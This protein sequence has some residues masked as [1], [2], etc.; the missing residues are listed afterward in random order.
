MTLEPH[1]LDKKT[2]ALCVLIF[3]RGWISI[4]A[5]DS[6]VSFPDFLTRS[7]QGTWRIA[8]TRVSLDS[9]IN[10]FLEGATPEEICQDYSLLSLAQVY[11][12]IAYYLT[13]RDEIDAYLQ[14][15]QEAAEKLQQELKARYGDFLSDL[16]RRLLA[17]GV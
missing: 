6:Q 11:S 5:M 4:L 13:R 3:S 10:S 7:P 9:I 1:A 2:T 16:R 17:H 14:E 8:G 12:A 15:Q